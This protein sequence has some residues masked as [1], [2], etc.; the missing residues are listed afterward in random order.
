MYFLTVAQKYVKFTRI[1]AAFVD[2]PSLDPNS[3]HTPELWPPAIP[4]SVVSIHL[5]PGS[6]VMWT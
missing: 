1:V 4:V 3:I 6:L 5:D 2:D